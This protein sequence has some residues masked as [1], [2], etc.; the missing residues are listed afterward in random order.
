MDKYILMNYVWIK[1]KEKLCSQY[2]SLPVECFINL[3]SHEKFTD[4]EV[5]QVKYAC[6]LKLFH[7]MFFKSI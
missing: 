4:V 7:R 2:K 6:I 3:I 5:I 1:L